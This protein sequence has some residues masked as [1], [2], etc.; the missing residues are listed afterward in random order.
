VGY[1]FRRSANFGPLRLNFS[2]S[3]IGASVGVKGARV[4]LTPLGT[5][6]VT[7]GSHGVYYRETLN[8]GGQQRTPG[9][10]QP[11][12]LPPTG[13]VP[14]E[15]ASAEPSDLVDS[16]SENLL[17]QLNERA[18]MWNPAIALYILSGLLGTGGLISTGD[19]QQATSA[20]ILL[21]V[22][23]GVLVIGFVVHK[24]NTD[25][26]TSRLFYELDGKEEQKHGQ[27]QQA[28]WSLARCSRIWRIDADSATDDWKRNAG[29]SS[30]IRRTPSAVVNLSPPRV[31]TNV[32]VPCVDMGRTKLFFLPD[33]V[34]C[35]QGGS[36]GAI[37]YNDLRVGQ[38]VT[39]LSR[40]KVFR[41]MRRLSVKAGSTSTGTAALTEGSTITGGFPWFNMDT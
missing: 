36:Y 28:F 3:G 25:R 16:S 24:K 33:A 2:K 40:I 37:A 21:V 20:A 13:T 31:K 6:Y 10:V 15:I 26:R 41:R 29:A 1:F 8:T 18:R 17:R 32:P 35:W 19:S 39:R 4:T 34:L 27:V 11:A 38:Q 22:A 5:T 12:L 7:V 30:L 9:E 14:G 23:L